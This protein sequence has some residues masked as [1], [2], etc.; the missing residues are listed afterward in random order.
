VHVPG[1]FLDLKSRK[2]KRGFKKIGQ[3]FAG[4]TTFPCD[5][6][7]FKNTSVLHVLSNYDI[8]IYS[9][10]GNTIKFDVKNI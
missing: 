1:V 9:N 6:L 8:Q 2:G 10:K 4:L 5:L 7:K 3:E